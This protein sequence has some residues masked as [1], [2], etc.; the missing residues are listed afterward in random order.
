MQLKMLIADDDKEL[1]DWIQLVFR[2]LDVAIFE[3]R[4]GRELLSVLQ[5]KGPFDLVITDLR[6]PGKSGLDA[7]SEARKLGITVGV[8]LL[9]GYAGDVTVE[10]VARVGNVVLLSKPVDSRDLLAEATEI[11]MCS[12]RRRLPQDRG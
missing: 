1:R 6:M 12:D 2:H 4:D 10:M 11:I 7:M 3:A 8:I 5:E 9:T